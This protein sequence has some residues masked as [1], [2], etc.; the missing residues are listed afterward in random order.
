V[1]KLLVASLAASL[2]AGVTL[3]APG[4]DAAPQN[5][6]VK[7]AVSGEKLAKAKDEFANPAED[8][9]RELREE[10]LTKVLKGN[11]SAV[12]RG[13]STVVKL[14]SGKKAQY[15][16]LS[17]QTVDRVFVILAEFGDQRHPSYPD[18]DTSTA[19]PGPVRFDG[20]LVNQIP[21]P[22][23][24]VDN[25][26]VWQP[27]YSREHFENMYFGD[28]PG[29]E[30][31][32]TY[33]EQQSSGSYSVSG[34]VTDWVKVTYNQARYGRSNGFPC[35]SN[36]CTNTWA[37]VRDAANQWYAD[38]L[39]SGRSAADVNAE[40]ATFDQWD[41]FDFDRDG[42]FNEPDGYIDHFQIVHAGGD[43]ADGDPI[44]GEDA[45]WSHRWATFQNTT[46]G[47][48]VPG[49][50][51]DLNG[52][53]EIGTSG[54]WI[55]DYTIQPENGGRSVFF[56]EYGH[57]LG[58]P[59]DYNILSGGDN[60]NEHWTLM[61]QSRLGAEGEDFIGDRA[62]DLGAWNKLQLGWLDYDVVDA[63]THQD[64]TI[65]LQA[66][67]QRA[68][69]DAQA[70]VVVLPKKEVV[71][72]LGAPAS[73]SKQF[74]SGTGNNFV[75]T[76]S[77][78]VTLGAGTS[79]LTFKARWDIEDCGA[80]PCDYAYVQ[81]D[82]GTGYVAI[83][84]SIAHAT[85]GNGID[86]TQATYTNATFDLSAFAGKTVSLRFAYST[87]PAASGNNADVIDGIFVDD[88]SVVSNGTEVLTDGAENGTT[89]WTA[90]G[91]SAEGE[92]FSTFHDGFYIAGQRAYTSYDKYL[93]SGPY[94]FGYGSTL[95]DKVDHYAYQQGLLVSY[96]D[97]AYADNDTFAHPGEGRNL[98]V[99]AHPAV[100]TRSDGV[101]W[102]SRVQVFDAPFNVTGTKAF[103]IHN[104]GTLETIGAHPARSTFNDTDT[105]W[106]A[107]L[108]NHGVKLPA[109]GV[110]IRVLAV[111]GTDM[112]IRVTS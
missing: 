32:K 75:H 89:G 69:K 6:V 10:A 39:A 20:P 47:P 101:P 81:V 51:P 1:K 68:G 82:D 57:D 17:R 40:L 77:R 63:R 4:A 35:A 12:R 110:Q 31:L 66:Q 52:G 41:R 14:G 22:D 3:S 2:A 21:Q 94:Y 27:N 111:N 29:V 90:D 106:F 108:P 55:R 105:Y 104:N 5:R 56:H 72:E 96:W 62:G 73:G 59:D 98:Y 64:K 19:T 83:P 80:D 13:A 34:T 28:G 60:N 86:G 87:D 84:G 24:T 42:D 79:T 107:S 112:R 16:E 109:V 18:Q 8:K 49:N 93:K 25:S 43:Q 100:M 7:R 74:Y 15:A 99:D 97:T 92:S 48:T 67:A 70:A 26:T 91:W 23:R 44:Y 95:P 30:S 46:T 85:E 9:R 36:V 50:G 65:R 61:A 45:I 78:D 103:S 11:A 53:N 54:I 37:L 71:H 76:L 38:Q 33:Y 102:R 88:I 58:L